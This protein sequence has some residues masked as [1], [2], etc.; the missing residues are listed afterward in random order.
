MTES[1]QILKICH[2]TEWFELP[3]NQGGSCVTKG[4]SFFRHFVDSDAT[5]AKVY[6]AQMARLGSFTGV[7]AV[8]LRGVY[9]RLVEWASTYTKDL[10]GSVYATEYIEGSPADVVDIAL[11]L[12]LS[13]Q[14]CALYLQ[15]LEQTRLVKWVYAAG[16]ECGCSRPSEASRE[17]V[18][19]AGSHGGRSRP[20]LTSLEAGSFCAETPLKSG[21]SPGGPPGV[22]GCP[23]G[24][25]PEVSGN[26]PG[27]PRENQ[28]S[29]DSTDLSVCQRINDQRTNGQRSSPA[30]QGNAERTE[31]TETPGGPVGGNEAEPLRKAGEGTERAIYTPEWQERKQAELAERAKAEHDTEPPS[32]GESPESPMSPTKSD[33][34]SGDTPGTGPPLPCGGLSETDQRRNKRIGKGHWATAERVFGLLGMTEA[35]GSE[36]WNNEVS[37]FA[38][39]IQRAGRWVDLV[40]KSLKH[41]AELGQM[42]TRYPDPHSRARIW[43]SVM[44]KRT[45]DRE[46]KQRSRS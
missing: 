16:S 28:R 22:A 15:C 30:G 31:A 7:E 13:E 42:A 41:A 9:Y 10:R 18:Y 21:P 6:F 39:S 37:S 46:R 5:A 2:Y 3:K 26:P 45:D 23:P 17:K 35:K 40:E 33:A 29:T 36:A 34:G 20:P 12:G 38:S 25:L 19:A 1:P 24:T 4:L 43:N 44:R 14:R 8:A 11:V 32:N 27:D